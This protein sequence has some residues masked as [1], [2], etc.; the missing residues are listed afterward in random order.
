MTLKAPYIERLDSSAAQTR[1]LAAALHGKH[2]DPFGYNLA[3]RSVLRLF[4]LVPNEIIPPAITLAA[5]II[6]IP[7]SAARQV[8][9]DGMTADVAALYPQKKYKTILVGA[10]NGAVSHIGSIMNAPFLTTHFLLCFRHFKNADD[11]Y[12]AAR[13]GRK[14][15]VEITKNNP[16]LNVVIHFDPVH[17]RPVVAF[18]THL[19]PKLRNL[20]AEYRRFI[21]TRLAPGGTIILVNCSFP[22][23][24]YRMRDRITFQIGGLGGIPD[25]AFVIGNEEVD[26]YL[27]ARG[28]LLRGGWR[29]KNSPHRL[30][31]HPESEWGLLPEFAESV[32]KFAA[33]RGVKLISLNADHPEKYS[34]LAFET[35]REASRI[36]GKEPLYVFADCFNQLDPLANINS[37]ILPLWLPYYDQSSYDLAA[38]LLNK[39]PPG[40]NTMLTMHPSFASPSDMVPL[41]RWIDLFTLD[42]PPKLFGVNKQKFP[43]DISYLYDFG[44]ELRRFSRKHND[45]VRARVSPEQIIQIARRIGFDIETSA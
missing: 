37:R 2:F 45:P 32:R 7:Q 17:D 12:A 41:Q 30:E 9:T 23:L 28:S 42:S 27:G 21:D 13:V 20:S 34:E 24:Q 25:S 40:V 18:I 3:Q 16:D 33:S 38:R 31:I 29:L 35:H 10:T 22:W 4:P 1:A 36:D 15:A 39:L 11:V 44:P 6:G 26:E 19:R 14:L 8:R 43:F 5:G